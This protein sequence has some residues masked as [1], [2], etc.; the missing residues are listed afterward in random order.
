M[1]SVLC[2]HQQ[3][4]PGVSKKDLFSASPRP[5]QKKTITVLN[6][7]TKLSPGRSD[8]EET[9]GPAPQSFLE[10]LNAD[11]TL[12]NLGDFANYGEDGALPEEDEEDEEYE[13]DQVDFYLF[14]L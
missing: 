10:S 13:D 11:I 6:I 4:P 3:L 9:E 1:C 2:K 14:N 12:D 7:T 5:S 8:E